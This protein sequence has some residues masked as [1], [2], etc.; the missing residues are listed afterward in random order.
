MTFFHQAVF[1]PVQVL[2]PIS[3]VRQA[4]ESIF[5][6]L[7]TQTEFPPVV[8]VSFDEEVRGRSLDRFSGAIK[9]VPFISFERRS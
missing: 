3:Q 2:H 8:R 9:H 5:H 1:Y 6:L 7:S 4:G